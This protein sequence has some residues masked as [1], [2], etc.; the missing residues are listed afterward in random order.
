MKSFITFLAV[1]GTVT[2]VSGSTYAQNSLSKT[3]EQAILASSSSYLT[4][5]D[6]YGT[7]YVLKLAR[8]GKVAELA[9]AAQA[10]SGNF[11][12]AH[13]SYGNNLFHVAKDAATVQAIAALIRHFYGPK[14]IQQITHMLDERN[15]SGEDPLMAQIN[16]GHADTFRPLYQSSSL[17]VENNAANQQVER[18][19][20]LPEAIKKRHTGFYCQ[21]I[22]K[23]GSSNS[24]TLVQAAQ[25]QIPYN[26][27]MALVARYIANEMPCLL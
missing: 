11:L 12:N 3:V 2:F 16:A 23:K 10:P 15:Q 17:R 24:R 22:L 1:L 20:G 21:E 5:P 19:R 25:A 14:A 27:D 13:D 6:S 18:L 8:Q 26:P 4:A 7:P 9:H